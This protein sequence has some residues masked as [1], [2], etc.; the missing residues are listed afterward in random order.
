MLYDPVD[1]DCADTFELESF[2]VVL[3]E[4]NSSR[5]LQ[6]IEFDRRLLQYTLQ[7]NEKLRLY[8]VLLEITNLNTE[9]LPYYQ[10]SYSICISEQPNVID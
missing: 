2:V 5:S 4:E 10:R 7:K 6:Y 9:H 8:E 3:T 1:D